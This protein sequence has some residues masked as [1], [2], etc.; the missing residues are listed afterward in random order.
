MEKIKI[1]EYRNTTDH[2]FRLNYD[3][4]QCVDKKEREYCGTIIS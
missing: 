2:L 4:S 3:L 1:S